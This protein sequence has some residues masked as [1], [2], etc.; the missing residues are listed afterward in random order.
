MRITR[1][2]LKRIIREE[3][4]RLSEAST[5]ATMYVGAVETPGGIRYVVSK[6]N[7]SDTLEDAKFYKTRASAQNLAEK[8]VRMESAYD[9][10]SNLSPTAV[11]VSI[12]ANL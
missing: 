3:V 6:Y 1:S 12:R 2:R 5:R 9:D 4:R 10:V 7:T 11:E 8:F